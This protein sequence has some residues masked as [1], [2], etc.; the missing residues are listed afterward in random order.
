MSAAAP[1]AHASAEPVPA[2]PAARQAMIESQLQPCG[3][4]AH[5]LVAA[6]H[7]VAREDFVDPARR[8]MAYVDAAQ[9]L[10]AGRTMMPP[11]SLGRLLQEGAPRPADHALV[12]GAGTGY[13][14]AILARLV[15]S[16]VALESD[17]AL[18]ARARAQ[19]GGTPNV[20]VAEG[21]LDAGWPAAAPYSF[22]LVD[23]AIEGDLPDA[24]VA[25]LAD[26]AR[27][28][29]IVIGADGVARAAHGR[30]SAGLLRLEPFAEAP[31]DVLPPF[32]QP[33]RFRF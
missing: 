31:A 22:L 12:V 2:A 33:P 4:V 6:F 3:V 10:G 14:A 24:L 15:G 26:G 5:A 8:A 28:A 32:R 21:A 20:T 19:L 16:V 9:P 11:L 30:K 18:A 7:A 1:T 25:Q 23:G 27:A 29:A 13:A 17:P